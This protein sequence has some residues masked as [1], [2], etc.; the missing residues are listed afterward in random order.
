[1][2]GRLLGLDVGDVRVG[3]AW[4]DPAGLTVAP[5][6]VFLRAG[7]AAEGK[8]VALIGEHHI[9][10]VVAGLP[11]S[12]HNEETEQSQKIRRFMRRVARRVPV[13]VAFVDEYLTSCEAA[14]LARGHS[15]DAVAAALILE[16]YLKGTGRVGE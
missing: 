8:I 4:T 7:G 16:S 15:T 6:G 12:E 5:L 9:E 13:E 1:M 11:L 2:G 10:R 3:V 14:G